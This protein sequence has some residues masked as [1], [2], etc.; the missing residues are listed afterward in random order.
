MADYKVS[1]KNDSEELLMG[2]LY[3]PMIN[4]YF[5]YVIPTR[6]GNNFCLIAKDRIVDRFYVAFLGGKDLLNYQYNLKVRRSVQPPSSQ[7]YIQH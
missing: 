1:H 6:H 5:E 2:H 7:N 3:E 4:H